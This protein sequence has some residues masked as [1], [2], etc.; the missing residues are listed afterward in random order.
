MFN[1][2]VSALAGTATPVTESILL[3]PTFKRYELD[4]SAVQRDSFDI[5]NNGQSAFNFVV[6][7]RPYSVKNELYEPDFVNGGQNS[8][9][10]KWVQFEQPSYTVEPGKTVKVN[11]TMRVPSDAAP[12]GHYGVLFAETQ[13]SDATEGTAIIRKKRVGAIVYATVNGDVRTSGKFEGSDAPFFQFNAPLKVRSTVSNSGNTDFMV[14]SSVRVSDVFGALKYRADKE[15]SILPQKPREVNNDWQ[16]P[17]WIGLYKVEQTN[18]FLDTTKATSA[19]VLLVP[20][21]VYL[22]L[23]SLIVGRILYAVFLRRRTK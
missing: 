23:V 6:Y 4:T 22:V 11:Y 16:N 15:V 12:G 14:K 20:I 10:Y 17:A 9:A 1:E 18:Q 13:P 3:S 5:L 2:P 8:D 21:W 19:Y 7:A